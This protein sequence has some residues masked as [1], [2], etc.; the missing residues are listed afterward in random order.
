MLV[1]IDASRAFLH[2]RTGIEEYSY[3]VI[4]H[5][6]D[7]IPK[8]DFVI[9][10]VRKKISLSAVIPSLSRNLALMSGRSFDFA[11]DDKRRKFSFFES[12]R[13]DFELP[14]NW[15][16]KGL[17][18][19]RFWT[20]IRLSLEM[21][22]HSPDVLFVPA[23][24]VPVIHPK[25]TVVTVHG[26]EYE[27]FPKAYS[28]WE[29]LYMRLSIRFSVRVADRIV[30]VSENTKRDLTR[31]YGVPEERI[32]VIYEGVS[33][34][35]PNS[36]FQGNQKPYLLFIG[37]LEERKNIVR[38][39]EAFGILKE[40]Y[41]IPHELVLAGKPGHGYENIRRKIQGARYKIRETGY[42]SEGEKRELLKNADVFLF[43]TLYEGFGL[44]V[45]E[46]Q[47]AGVPV[48]AS[49]TSSLPEV[50]GEGALYADPLSPEDIAEQTWKFLSE[51]DVR[52]GIMGAGLENVR[53]F[54]W[55]KCSEKITG[56]LR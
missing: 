31:L 34:E 50:G 53:R 10:Y 18:A 14:K 42:V 49:K 33:L 43:P 46:A 9:L 56:L 41:H 27:M 22:F 29:R 37:R 32:A 13:M 15:E 12:P 45:L 8:G 40:K 7:A 44:P 1:G 47:A 28:F 16:V 19:P 36:K 30:A 35:I 38:I 5:L 26:L 24:T 6:R 4:R 17:W 55:R 3:Q 23:H 48:V 52:D 21:L 25:K 54:D 2:R 51:K 39:I 11:Q 20:Q